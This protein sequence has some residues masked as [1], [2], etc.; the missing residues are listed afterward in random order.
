M[1]AVLALAAREIRSQVYSPV[2]WAVGAGFL[3]LAGYFFFNFVSQ[4]ALLLRNYGLYAQIYQNPAILDRV[5]LNEMVVAGLA[6]SLLVLLLF[7]VPILTMRSFAEERRQ[8]TDELILTAPVTPLQIVVGKYVGSISVSLSIVGASSFFAGVLAR[9]GDPEIGPIWTAWAGL[10][11]AT[12]ALT[13]LGLAASAATG[14][15]A[16]AG[17][18][19]FVTFLLLFVSDWPAESVGETLGSV[20]RAISLPERFDGFSRGVV[21]SPDV[22]YFLSLVALGLFAARN[23]VASKRWR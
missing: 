17:F 5:N 9:Y 4:F 2:A 15:Q 7:M 10:L 21:S 23:I 22:F 3:L 8:G 12:A 6:R 16:V 13:A 11:L 20:L 19:S 18:G 14:S 1:R